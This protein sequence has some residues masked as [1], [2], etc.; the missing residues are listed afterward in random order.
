MFPLAP[1]AAGRDPDPMARLPDF[2]R[3]YFWEVDFETLSLP[4][5]EVYT[6]ERILEY[7]DDRAIRWLKERFAASAIGEV[8]RSSRSLS[9]NTARL[10]SLF[11]GI[12]EEEV[13]CFSRRSLPMPGRS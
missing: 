3:P 4:E 7:G 5:H 9:P 6:I 1:L 11:L 2:L 12:P 10:W 8:V 13:A